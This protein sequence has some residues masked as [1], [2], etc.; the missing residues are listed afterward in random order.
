MLVT[1]FYSFK[2]GSGCSMLLANVGWILASRGHRVLLWDCDFESPG[3][4]LLPDLQPT[5]VSSGFLDWLARWSGTKAEVSKA[6]ARSLRSLVLPVKDQPGLSILPAF[7]RIEELGDVLERLTFLQ[8]IENDPDLAT[9]YFRSVLATLQVD[10][11]YV[12]IDSPDGFTHLGGLLTGLLPHVAVLVG[13]YGTRPHGLRH[14]T[15]SLS[16]SP[17]TT[18]LRAQAVLDDLRTLTVASFTVPEHEAA[19]LQRRAWE[20]TMGRAPD[21]E[22]P[23]DP[24]LLIDERL[25]ACRAST[26]PVLDACK[27]VADRLEVLTRQ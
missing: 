20:E 6:R 4:H 15:E 23:F 21:I 7:D 10:Y 22:V 14:V 11:D 16:P 18:A 17:E 13:K 24:Q 19:T 8:T 27:I 2:G 1:T 12:L 26:S 9:A 5:H 25:P 3:L